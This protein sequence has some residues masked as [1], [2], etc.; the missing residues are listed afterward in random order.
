M[1]HTLS[2]LSTDESAF[3][4]VSARDLVAQA[5]RRTLLVAAAATLTWLLFV[6]MARSAL[7]AQAMPAALAMAVVA[8]AAL[9][10]FRRRSWLGQAA[11]L[12]GWWAVIGLA[13][14]LLE[15]PEALLF[16]AALPLIGAS[17]ASAGLTIAA[18]ALIAASLWAGAWLGLPAPAAAFAH[19]LIPA[20]G[21]VALLGWTTASTLLTSTRRSLSFGSRLLSG[22]YG[23]G[24]MAVLAP[25][26]TRADLWAAFRARRVYGVTGDRIALDFT[27]NGAA[28]G[29]Q[30]AAAPLRPARARRAPNVA[31][32]A[33]LALADQHERRCAVRRGPARTEDLKTQMR[34]RP[35]H[36]GDDGAG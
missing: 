23:H 14:A 34:E 17:S 10:L 29:S 31:G 35:A 6:G 2:G 7:A 15:L 1:V 13:A 19:L 16:W 36:G 18:C 12:I 33:P 26:L 4:A 3:V 5:T 8:A 24:L 22:M 21:L 28:M 30:I 25:A 11:F 9:R 20:G 27:V 32:A